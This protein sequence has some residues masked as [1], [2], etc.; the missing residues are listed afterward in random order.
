MVQLPQNSIPG[1]VSGAAMPGA[2]PRAKTDWARLAVDAAKGGD[3]QTAINLFVTAISHDQRNAGLRYNLAIVLERNGETDD[4]A[5]SLTD[6]LRLKPGMP[7]AAERLS[8]VLSKYE[9]M[10]PARLDA[11]GLMSALAVPD[12]DAESIG[13]MAIS[14]LKIGGPLNEALQNGQW[15]GWDDTADALLKSRTA[16]LLRDTLFLRAISCHTNQDA[17][18]E[19]LLTALRRTVLNLASERFADKTVLAFAIALARQCLNNEHVFDLTDEEQESALGFRGALK[20]TAKMAHDDIKAAL[21]SLMYASTNEIMAHAHVDGKLHGMKPKALR[22]FLLPLMAREKSETE[23][24]EQI[25]QVGALNGATTK[26]VAA[27]YEDRPYPRWTT[28]FA[29][30]EGSLSRVLHRFI[31]EHRLAFMAQPFNALI[32]GCGTGR[33]ALEASIGYGPNARITAIDL[34][35]RSLAYAAREAHARHIRNITFAQADLLDETA[36]PG[37]FDIIECVGVLHHLEQPLDGLRALERRLK[38]GGIMQIALYSAVSREELSELRLEPQFPGIDCSDDE[39]RRYRASL[40]DRSAETTGGELTTSLDFWSMSG[41]RDLVLHVSEQQ[42]TLP[43]ISA[44]LS[45]LG[46]VFRGFTLHPQHISEF[47]AAHPGQSWPG[48]LEKWWAWE[49]EHPRLFDGMYNFW[50]EKPDP[51]QPAPLA[52]KR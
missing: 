40:R 39:A 45:E 20:L 24:A 52:I 16:P 9:I 49:Q 38:P 26:K 17:D 28:F 37:T 35:R 14:I 19:H 22:E 21:V 7:E 13:S 29:P 1:S 23:I 11:A 31:P 34:S 42:F 30:P 15:S 3:Y 25:P 43:E 36:C 12:V 46:L 32:A 48:S 50:V 2:L 5:V 41:F 47:E 8:R 44:A 4:A 33:H 51:N 27:Q 6:A 10:E 18:V